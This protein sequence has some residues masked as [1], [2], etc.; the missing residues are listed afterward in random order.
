MSNFPTQ[1]KIEA[2]LVRLFDRDFFTSMGWEVPKRG[3]PQ[4]IN[5]MTPALI[6]W[7]RNPNNMEVVC[8]NVVPAVRELWENRWTGIEAYLRT[9]AIL[10]AARAY[11]A[12]EEE[13]R[14]FSQAIR[15]HLG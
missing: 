3:I 2:G 13:G 8:T 14:K 6:A 4:L 11:V 12:R 7:N 5:E 9:G 15:Q 1:D 10:E